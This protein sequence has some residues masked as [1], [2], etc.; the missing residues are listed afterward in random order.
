MQSEESR[1]I[2]RRSLLRSGLLVGAGAVAL[3]AGSAAT[4]PSA[5]AGTPPSQVTINGNL[6]SVQGGWRYCKRCGVMFFSSNGTGNG[7][8][9]VFGDNH[10]PPLLHAPSSSDYGLPHGGAAINGTPGVQVGW[11]WC[12][13]C[14]NLFWGP[15]VANSVCSQAEYLAISNQTN[16]PINHDLGSGTA[17]DMLFGGWATS[18]VTLQAGWNFCRL[19]KGLYHGNGAPGGICIAG[20]PT[21]EPLS[22]PTNYQVIIS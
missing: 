1:G 17:Y 12:D 7:A 15:E 22:N 4:A 18:G 10:T 19:C 21:H 20:S 8:C 16:G 3:G 9:A 11:R 2:N 6:Y 13:L 14:Q 5:W